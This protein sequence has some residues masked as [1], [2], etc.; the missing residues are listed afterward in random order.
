MGANDAAEMEKERGSR[1]YAKA[2]K[3]EWLLVSQDTE[4]NR[5]FLSVAKFSPESPVML[6]DVHG[7]RWNHPSIGWCCLQIVFGCYL[8]NLRACTET[9]P[10]AL[11]LR[12][13]PGESLSCV[14][15]T[16][17]RGVRAGKAE[18]RMYGIEYL[19]ITERV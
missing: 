18:L 4:D 15:T 13:R 1:G 5:A 8:K 10:F 2:I 3:R 12:I 6:V 17:G 7:F 16:E 14:V 9:F 11:P 19:P